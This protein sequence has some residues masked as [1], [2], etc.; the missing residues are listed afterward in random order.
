MRYFFRLFLAV[1]LTVFA[2]LS[3]TAQSDTAEKPTS[4]PIFNIPDSI[5]KLP[6]RVAK[7]EEEKAGLSARTA[8]KDSVN[9]NCGCIVECK[10]TTLTGG[11]WLLVFL[12]VSLFFI[13]GS[14]FVYLILKGKFDLAEALSTGEKRTET[15]QL[16]GRE[17]TTTKPIGSTSRLLAFLTGISAILIALCLV[18]YSAYAVVAQCSNV[19]FDALWKILLG[20]GIGVIPYG[21]NVLNGN[22]KEKQANS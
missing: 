21:M 2:S 7:L 3:S 16:E 18:T 9:K 4:A 22:G 14:Y 8:A 17:T 20:L 19:N 10:K 1:A 5:K 12:P 13:V 15:V 11:D 6:S